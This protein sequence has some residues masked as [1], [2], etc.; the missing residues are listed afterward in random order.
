MIPRKPTTIVVTAEDVHEYDDMISQAE[1][2]KLRVNKGTMNDQKS[3]RNVSY[4]NNMNNGNEPSPTTAEQR[5]GLT[6]T[7]R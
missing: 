1:E 4:S 5:I 7:R 2:D 6:Q 3:Q